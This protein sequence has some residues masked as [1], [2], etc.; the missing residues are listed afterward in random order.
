MTDCIQLKRTG[1]PYQEH[2]EMDS[3]WALL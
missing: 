3:V 2:S 1:E